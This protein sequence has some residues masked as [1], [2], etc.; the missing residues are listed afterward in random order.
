MAYPLGS[1]PMYATKC[2]VSR[3]TCVRRIVP[4]ANARSIRAAVA[5]FFARGD[6]ATPVKAAL[7][8]A[9]RAA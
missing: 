4:S 5:P 7:I 3:N 6:T 9:A 1:G 2:Q 8:R